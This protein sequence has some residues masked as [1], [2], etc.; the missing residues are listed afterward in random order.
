MNLA[1]RGIKD[2]E[3]GLGKFADDTFVND[4]HKDLKADFVLANPPFNISDWGQ[5]KLLDDPQWKYGIP[6]KGNEARRRGNGRKE[7]QQTARQRGA[8][9]GAGTAKSSPR[10][11]GSGAGQQRSS[12]PQP[13]QRAAAAGHM[14]RAGSAD[15]PPR[16]T[17]GE[18]KG[19]GNRTVNGAWRRQQAGQQGRGRRGD[20]RGG[21][22]R[23]DATQRR[24][25][26]RRRSGE[27]Q[28][29][30]TGGHG[31]AAAE[32]GRAAAAARSSAGGGRQRREQRAG[33][34]GN[35]RHTGE[36]RG[37]QGEAKQSNARH[38]DSRRQA[39]GADRAARE[40]EA[41]DTRQG[42][43]KEKGRGGR[44]GATDGSTGRER[45]WAL[46]RRLEALGRG[47]TGRG[48]AEGRA[49]AERSSVAE[50]RPRLRGSR[51]KQRPAGRQVRA[52]RRQ[53][54]GRRFTADEEAETGQP[55]PAGS[56]RT[57]TSE[58]KT[59]PTARSST[60]GEQPRR[61][62]ALA[63][64]TTPRRTHPS[65]R[66]QNKTK[67]SETNPPR[68]GRTCASDET[69]QSDWPQPARAWAHARVKFR[70]LP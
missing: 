17:Q 21:D 63:L 23:Q 62:S 41:E 3:E 5:E 20:G 33:R 64:K 35:R 57:P 10:R 53:R 22:R 28:R 48:N 11:A 6:P 61:T 59:R 16:T 9:V 8:P 27:A 46:A 54:R 24:K 32:D 44:E 45:R 40:E 37:Q 38:T 29:T 51:P 19:D 25:A 67:A 60:P 65:R 12:T 43:R 66:Q 55:A 1:I 70:A 68:T 56:G 42:G 7:R 49:D 30:A 47:S 52:T 31:E 13:G 34:L 50:A 39:A 4:L 14:G 15:K 36:R 58:A 2:N 69:A 26:A 18:G